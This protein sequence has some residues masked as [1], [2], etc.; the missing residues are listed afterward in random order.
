ML[1]YLSR[2]A[3]RLAAG[4]SINSIL[5][6]KRG[7]IRGADLKEYLKSQQPIWTIETSRSVADALERIL[8]QRVGALIV[9]EPSHSIAGIVTD[10]DLLK[11]MRQT[12]NARFPLAT[13]PVTRI[14]TPAVDVVCV[15]PSDT[16]Q[17][18]V[19]IMKAR[20]IR[21]LPVVDGE[22]LIGM[23]SVADLLHAFPSENTES[24]RATLHPAGLK[25]I[26]KPPE[27]KRVITKWTR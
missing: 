20:G 23:I 6:T 21:H 17:Q 27:K 13:T 16:R 14:M 7:G 12:A 15:G 4:E 5:E 3:S 18:A 19:D 2:L 24:F 26:G 25:F 8:E 9:T 11:F 10:R 22:K 1:K